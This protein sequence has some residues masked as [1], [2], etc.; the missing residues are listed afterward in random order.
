MPPLTASGAHGVESRVHV[1]VVLG[2]AI[3]GGMEIWVERMVA[4][5]PADRF[6]FTVVCPFESPMAQRLRMLGCPVHIVPIPEEPSWNTIN[7]I[8]VL[9]E[10]LQVDLVHAHLPNAHL[11]AGVAARLAGRPILTTIHGRHLTVLDL[12]AHRAVASHLSVVC[13]Y[14]HLH[15][16]GLG[17]DPHHL[18]CDPNGVDTRVFQP[19][20][21]RGALRRFL[22][23]PST[24][25]LVGFVGRL[26]HEKGPDVLVRAALILRQARPDV[27]VVFV[28][29]GPCR[30][31]LEAL[32]A[33]LKLQSCVHMIGVRQDMPSVYNE[34]D[35][36]ASTSHTEAMP[37]AIM[38]AM[39]CGLPVVATRTGGV[40]D[41]VQDGRTGWLTTVGDF[42]D[43]ARRLSML[44]SDDEGRRRMGIAARKHAVTQWPLDGC[45]TRLTELIERLSGKVR[46]SE[47]S[48]VV[49]N[50]SVVNGA[51]T[52]KG[53][54]SWQE[55]RLN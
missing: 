41:M 50:S 39:A 45:V 29:E 35:V 37:L 22:Q 13:Q 26:S 18:T 15:A 8:R 34:L 10:C 38:E 11:V 12:E 31:G 3:V 46:P 21:T 7:Q 1:L 19:K 27:H 17:V 54:K 16:L 30:G 14:S 55:A 25:P 32:I 36:M 6:D 28:G 47:Q 2:N 42:E 40:P 44:L 53:N 51:H 43:I 48:A 52:G 9:I 4:R 23:L 5:L 49:A 20:R 33:A 24:A